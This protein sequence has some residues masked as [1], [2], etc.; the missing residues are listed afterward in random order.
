M[1]SRGCLQKDP[2]VLIDLDRRSYM[3][4]SMRLD[5]RYEV[6]RRCGFPL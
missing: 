4:L 6:A 3:V 1:A 2:L 5:L